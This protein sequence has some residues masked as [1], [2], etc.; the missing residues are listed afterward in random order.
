MNCFSKLTILGA[1]L[2][3]STTIASATPIQLGSY[4]N[5][6]SS[7]GNSNTAVVWVGTET[8]SGTPT[9]VVGTA[10]GDF[11]PGGVSATGIYAGAENPGTTWAAPF[12]NSTWVGPASCFEPGSGNGSCSASLGYNVFTTTFGA[13]AGTYNGT[14]N[15]LADDTVEVLLNGAVLLNFGALGNDSTCAQY[16]TGCL[17][18]TETNLALSGITLDASNTLEF[19][20]EQA[21]NPNGPSGSDPTGVDFNANLTATPE[22]GS[23]VL[24]GTGL[25]GAA[26]AARRRFAA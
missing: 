2:A 6:S 23:L 10:N 7:Q 5:G 3:A 22:P 19:V 4:A 16:A 24:L 9:G 1:V 13:T 11:N 20:V 14:L 18:S 12:A 25:L 21:G 17:T 8:T 26:A 15:V